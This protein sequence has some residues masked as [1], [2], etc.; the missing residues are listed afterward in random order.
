MSWKRFEE[1]C[2]ELAALGFEKLDRKICYLGFSDKEGSPRV[3]PITPSIGGGMLFMFTEPTSPKIGDLRRDGRYALHSAVGREGPL[4]EF[5][6]TGSAEL[7]SDPAQRAQAERI[8]AAPVVIDSYA[9]FEFQVARVL[10]VEYDEEKRKIAHRWR[11][12]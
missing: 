9:L 11:S 1:A 5:L 6:V 12:D 8:A 2:P 10:V 7:I 3:H 4:I